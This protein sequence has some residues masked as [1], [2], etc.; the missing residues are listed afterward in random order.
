MVP[1]K[2]T[3]QNPQGRLLVGCEVAVPRKYFST[4]KCL[5]HTESFRQRLK[6]WLWW[7]WS[8]G[9]TE[10]IQT[11]KG[12]LI[13]RCYICKRQLIK[14]NK[15]WMRSN[16]LSPLKAKVMSDLPSINTPTTHLRQSFIYQWRTKEEEEEESGRLKGHVVS[17]V[18]LPTGPF[19]VLSNLKRISY[20]P[21][22]W[23]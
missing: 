13:I 21:E 18:I 17:Q 7:R 15:I 5:F 4:F 19:I 14:K 20:P 10:W 1:L 2:A 11:N 9:H 8:K 16:A 22:F 12:P 23:I 6:S 3:K